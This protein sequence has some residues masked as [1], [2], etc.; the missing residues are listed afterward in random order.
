MLL[1]R[2]PAFRAAR[3]SSMSAHSTC[4]WWFAYALPSLSLLPTSISPSVI[5]LACS[6]QSDQCISESE[7]RVATRTEM[8]RGGVRSKARCSVSPA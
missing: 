7:A 8:H 1:S 5:S 3:Q 2:R 4:L 6:A